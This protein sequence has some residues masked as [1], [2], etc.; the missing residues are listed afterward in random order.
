MPKL[1][2]TTRDG[3]ESVV[4]IKE[5]FFTLGR[6][7][8][9]TVQIR[10]RG[11]SKRHARF[12]QTA[13]GYFVVDA[14]SKNGIHLN[15]RRVERALLRDGD[16]LRFGSRVSVRWLEPVEA[17]LEQLP[18]R[19]KYDWDADDE[20]GLD[21]PPL[22]SDPAPSTGLPPLTA[23]LAAQYETPVEPFKSIDKGLPVLRP[24]EPAQDE[25]P[26]TLYPRSLDAPLAPLELAPTGQYSAPTADENVVL[27]FD[28]IGGFSGPA[29]A[30]TAV[31]A[32]PDR[33]DVALAR[34]R[35][36]M[37]QPEEV[38]SLDQHPLVVRLRV[39]AEQAGHRTLCA[40]AGGLVLL[41]VMM[42]H[43][44]RAMEHRWQAG[45]A[46]TARPRPVRA[47]PAAV[48]YRQAESLRET[49]R[50]AAQRL[51]ER[52]IQQHPQS[53]WA[54]LA[55]ARRARQGQT[56]TRSEG[57]L[58]ATV[59]RLERALARERYVEA[60]EGYALLSRS[61]PTAEDRGKFV[62]RHAQIENQLWRAYQQRR[63][64]TVDPL[65][66]QGKKTEALEAGEKLLAKFPLSRVREDLERR[67]K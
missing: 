61:A 54:D 25:P 53:G 50:A 32:E 29:H 15:E 31:G 19:V 22:S 43:S 38:D 2:I 55:R 62:K 33:V 10:D 5:P 12:Y 7:S 51:L 56:Q 49:D 21:L 40:C 13:D 47:D 39:V 26:P 27:P 23:E 35:A 17:T 20:Q 57:E 37:G 44:R 34:M 41:A 52:L 59:G 67:L 4:E 24:Q 42:L 63:R 30:P 1:I 45:P 6:S 48:L 58:T 28:S 36:E 46:P 8:E 18:E 11:L 3:T 65:L 60:L 64:S 66:Q 9:C 14:G 16:E